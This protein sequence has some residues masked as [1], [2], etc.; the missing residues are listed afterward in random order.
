M[1][2]MIGQRRAFRAAYMLCHNSHVLDDIIVTHVQ[3]TH[4]YMYMYMYMYTCTYV[5]CTTLV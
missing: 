3:A 4:M 5:Y 2:D 1:S